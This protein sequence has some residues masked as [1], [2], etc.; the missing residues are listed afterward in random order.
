MVVFP[1]PTSFVELQCTQHV[2]LIPT[3]DIGH[4]IIFGRIDDISQNVEIYLIVIHCNG[5][6]SRLDTK[7]INQTPDLIYHNMES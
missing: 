2:C 5:Y 1:I 6:P 4:R 3:S 7:S